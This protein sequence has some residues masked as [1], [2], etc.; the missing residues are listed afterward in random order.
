RLPTPLRRVA[1]VQR[2]AVEDLP[3][4]QEEQAAAAVRHWGGGA[5]QGQRLLRDGL[6]QRGVQERRQ[7][8][9]RR[10]Q[11]RQFRQFRQRRRARQARRRRR[12]EI[13]QAGDLSDR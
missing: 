5:V 3:R 4:V 11:G 1:V 2:P 6:P 9:Q 13:L 10:G 8:R 12:R 7:G